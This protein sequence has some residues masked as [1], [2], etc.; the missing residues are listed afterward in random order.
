M[1]FHFQPLEA[2]FDLTYHPPEFAL[3]NQQHRLEA[4]YQWSEAT[5]NHVIVDRTV[6]PKMIIVTD[7]R[8]MRC[9]FIELKAFINSWV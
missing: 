9:S 4:S 1:F 6:V 7:L 8:A 5:T 2:E 3:F